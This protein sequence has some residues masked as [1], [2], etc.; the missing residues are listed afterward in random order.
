MDP[1]NAAEEA[2]IIGADQDRP[3]CQGCRRRKL[4][5]SRE[6]PTCSQCQR[7]SSPC[8]YDNKR[9]KPGLKT[10]A[11]EGLS[12]RI[13]IVTN[14]CAYVRQVVGTIADSISRGP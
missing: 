7:L 1:S 2:T 3:S 9:S 5:C 6:S 8:V 11:V 12:R 10:G 13:G 14:S 4:K